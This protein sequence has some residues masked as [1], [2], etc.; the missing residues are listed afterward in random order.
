M[1]GLAHGLATAV[2]TL[3]VLAHKISQVTDGAG[4][5]PLRPSVH[6]HTRVYSRAPIRAP[7]PGS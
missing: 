4:V 7:G 1:P 5:F 3:Q 2:S 6:S